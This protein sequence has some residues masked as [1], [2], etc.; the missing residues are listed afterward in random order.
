MSPT[1]HHDV[2]VNGTVYP[3]LN[4][5]PEWVHNGG[6]T[7]LRDL[8]GLSNHDL[9]AATA[10]HELG[11]A[12]VWLVGGLHVSGLDLTSDGRYSGHA[13]AV[14]SGRS[15]EARPLTI[16]MAAG[17]R[18]EDRWL[19]EAG[20]WTPH[21]AAAVELGAFTDRAQ[22]LENVTPKPAFGTG[23]LD[24]TELHNMAD[25]AVDEVWDR[26]LFALPR[27][28]RCRAMSGRELAQA[29]GLP[30]PSPA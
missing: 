28:V 21:R 6:L 19:R 7:E 5:P 26:L 17:E 30:M 1:W 9:L 25:A 11:H 13:V 2:H 14:P 18:A 3:T 4:R 22:V 24:Y 20:L 10:A 8:M 27:L 12:L 29:A 16:G 23:G 15:D